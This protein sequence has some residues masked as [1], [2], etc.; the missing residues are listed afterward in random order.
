MKKFK[1]TLN[2]GLLVVLIAGAFLLAFPSST[3]HAEGLEEPPPA[4]GEK[5]GIIKQQL[6]A[7]FERQQDNLV[8][9]EENI[10]KLSQVSTSAQE[11][12]DSLREKGKDVSS[13]E[14]ALAEFEDA[15]PRINELHQETA[16]L[17]SSHAGFGNNGKVTEIETAARTVKIIRENM[18]K[19]RR[20][21]NNAVRELRIAVLLYRDAKAPKPTI[22]P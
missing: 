8:K 1:K 3:A 13:L 2:G 15:I 6:E 4:N 19:T 16:D 17:I 7:A 20:I 21:M 22:K 12:I 14:A 9:Q 5:A 18:M 11:R 10:E